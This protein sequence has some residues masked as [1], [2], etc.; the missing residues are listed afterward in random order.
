LNDHIVARTN[1]RFTEIPITHLSTLS[2]VGDVRSTARALLSLPREID[3][4][5]DQP[6]DGIGF[7]RDGRQQGDDRDESEEGFGE[8]HRAYWCVCVYVFVCVCECVY[9]YVCM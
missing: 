6:T 8:L 5:D 2:I 3:F 9:V 4:L 1:A 7:G